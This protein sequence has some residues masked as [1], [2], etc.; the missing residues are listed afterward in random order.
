[1]KRLFVIFVSTLISISAIS[2]D[3]PQ[4]RKDE[5]PQN[6]KEDRFNE[7]R[8]NGVSGID[9]LKALEVLG[10][11]IFDIPITPVFEKEYS[12]S[13]TL[14]EYKNGKKVNSK[15]ILNHPVFRKNTYSHYVE[16]TRYFDYI[17]KYTIFSKDNDK[18]NVLTISHLGGSTG[19]L[20]LE[21]QKKRKWQ[22]YLWRAYSVIDWKLNE[23]I[24]LLVYASSYYD[25]R[26][27]TDRFCGVVDLSLDEARTKELFD[28]S[29]HYYV[30]SLKVYE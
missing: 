30:I 28:K 3:I 12:I 23:K 11:R 29:P 25:K 8:A 14:D 24:P 1:M 20:K 6:V 26:I 7:Y 15:E 19:R 10:V 5:R 18:D 22:F 21:K 16:E 2:Q 13:L 9:I 27:K 17:P 4:Y